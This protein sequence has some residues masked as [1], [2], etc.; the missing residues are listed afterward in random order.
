MENKELREHD[1]RLMQK[2]AELMTAPSL[3]GMELVL[4]HEEY[5]CR[6][7]LECLD[8]IEKRGVSA[9]GGPGNTSGVMFAEII[10]IRKELPGN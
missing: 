5:A 1:E 2:C 4:S 8:R 3:S 9:D 10:A 6:K 7:V